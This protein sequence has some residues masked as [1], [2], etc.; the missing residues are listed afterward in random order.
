[1]SVL[2][3]S[4]LSPWSGKPLQ[5]FVLRAAPQDAGLLGFGSVVLSAHA[6]RHHHRCGPGV[7]AAA[8][9]TSLPQSPATGLRALKVDSRE[10]NKNDHKIKKNLYDK[11]HSQ[12]YRLTCSP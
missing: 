7:G 9:N 8:K 1:M 2:L 5:P 10:E 6:V 12:I 11:F 4:H 3:L